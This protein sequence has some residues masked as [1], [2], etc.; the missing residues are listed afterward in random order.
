MGPFYPRRH[1]PTR[2]P[3]PHP[4]P[5]TLR[6][7][8]RL[9]PIGTLLAWQLA[10][11]GPAQAKAGDLDPSFGIGGKVTTDFGTIDDAISD[12]MA[13]QA[14]GKPVAAGYANDGPA[15]DFALA[16]YTP[17]GTLDPAFGSGGTV[18]TDFYGYTDHAQGGLVVQPDGKLVAAGASFTFF[19]GGNYDFA[20]ARYNPDGTPDSSF[21][22]GGLVT[23]GISGGDDQAFAIALQPDGKL[24]AAGEAS[25][26]F[27]LARYNPD[28]TLDPSFNSSGLVTTDFAGGL[29]RVEAL[30]VQ[31]DGMLVAAGQAFSGAS[32]DFALARY[33][34]DGTLDES[35]GSGGGKVTTDLAGGDD[36]G[37]FTIAILAGGKLVAQG[38]GF[39]GAGQDFTLARY[40]PNGTLDSAFGSGG[41]VTTDFAGGDDFGIGLVVQAD[42]KLVAGGYAFIGALRD[43]ALARYKPNGTLDRTFGR[44][45]K[46][47][48][49]FAGG[50]NG[51]VTLAIQAD[52]KLVAGGFAAGPD[53]YDFALARYRA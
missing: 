44:Q 43:F 32:L 37:F 52:G 2:A 27:A 26:D 14:D 35:F 33:H 18:T 5:R 47:T 40:N 4:S 16:R 20:L 38:S 34:P 29:D 3:R 31:A 28:G 10:M 21:G 42:G 1:R 48:T 8:A 41:K 11:A 36:A 6:A 39:T 25:G 12:K 45:G 19:T 49:D 7:V 53:G 17:S 15:R 23:T 50:D 46:L 9:L 22:T 24:V 30:A 51:A 13:V